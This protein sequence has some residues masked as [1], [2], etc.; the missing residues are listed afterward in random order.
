MPENARYVLAL[1][2]AVNGCG[3]CIYDGKN[4]KPLIK[5]LE[6]MMRGQAEAL[7]PLVQNA[8]NQSSIDFGDIGLVATTIGP[9]TFSGLRVGLSAAKSYALALEKPLYGFSTLELLAMNYANNVSEGTNIC[10][11]IESKRQDFYFQLFDHQ[12]KPL[13][14]PSALG[15]ADVAGIIKQ[16]SLCHIIGDGCG[17]FLAECQDK[18][19]NIQY[20]EGFDCPDP[21]TLAGMA[22]DAYVSGVAGHVVKPL[23][24]RGADVSQPKVKPRTL[25]ASK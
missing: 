9:G 2:S 5:I 11:L 23:Y 7:I 16:Q 21:E 25:E 8:I 12:A 17:R 22:F 13:Y 10:I 24:L 14:E 18:T 20:I 4:K 15:G 3:V 19:L 1:D 6:P